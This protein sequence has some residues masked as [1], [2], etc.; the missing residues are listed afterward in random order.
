MR[1][2]ATGLAGPW[3]I[4][5]GPDGQLWVTERDAFRVVQVNPVDGMRRT[6]L[7][8][9]EVHRSASSQDGLLGLAFHPD[10]RARAPTRCS[11]RLPTMTRR[12]RRWRGASA[13]AA[14][15][16]TRTREPWSIRWTCCRA[17]RLTTI[18]SAGAGR[19]PRSQAVP[20]DRRRRRNFG[21]NRCMANHA[22]TLP[23]AAQVSARRT[24]VR[25]T[26]ARSCASIWTAAS[27]PTTRRLAACAATSSRWAT[28]TRWASR[29]A[30][31]P[32][33]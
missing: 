17:C 30:R 21:G 7:T 5:W 10:L 4:A 13:F 19:G 15:G 8:V 22:Q 16:M 1:V 29:S 9:H 2:V 6:L 25:A 32:A 33:V 20:D 14:I 26:R 24:G 3:E 11:W 23:T 27:R 31:R 18:T 28:A 12:A